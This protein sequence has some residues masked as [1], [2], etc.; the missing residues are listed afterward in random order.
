MMD[1]KDCVNLFISEGACIHEMVKEIEVA[2][3]DGRPRS[4]S[5]T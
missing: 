5:A 3:R 2:R 4:R 1:K